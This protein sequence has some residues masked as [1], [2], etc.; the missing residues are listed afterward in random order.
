MPS[1]TTG[2]HTCEQGGKGQ[3]FR[4]PPLKTTRPPSPRI[5]FGRNPLQISD[6]FKENRQFLRAYLKTI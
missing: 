4:P 2:K 6:F 5:E 1:S 3:N